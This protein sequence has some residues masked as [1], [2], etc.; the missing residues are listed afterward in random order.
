MASAPSPVRTMPDALQ[1]LGMPSDTPQDLLAFS[2]SFFEIRGRLRLGET[3]V[4]ERSL[5]QRTGMNVVTLWRERGH[6]TSQNLPLPVA[7]PARTSSL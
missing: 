3:M 6:W 7:T 5:V 1:R 4:S 2:S